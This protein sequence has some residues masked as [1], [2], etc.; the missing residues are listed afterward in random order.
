MTAIMH[1]VTLIVA[2]RGWTTSGDP[3]LFGRPGGELPD[4]FLATL[5]D[6]STHVEVLCPDLEMSMFSMRSAESLAR[7][8]FDAISVRVAAGDV[9]RI[10]LL[11][12][13]T[14]SILA[15][16]VFCMAHGAQRDGTVRQEQAAPWADLIDRNVVLSGITRGWE[17]SSASP[18][19]VRF[20]GPVLYYMSL[21]IGYLKRLFQ[22]GSDGRVAPIPLVYQ[23][24]RGAPFVIASRIQYVAVM[25]ALSRRPRVTESAPLRHEGLPSTVFLLGAQDEFIS[26]A[27]CT[28]LGPRSEF[29]FIELPGTSHSEAIK[30]SDQSPMSLARRERLLAAIAEPLSEL[31]E[32]PWVIPA[33]DIDDYLDPMD[34]ADQRETEA[35]IPEAVEHVVM[36]VHGIRDDGFWTKRVAREIKSLARLQ[37]QS[38]RAPTPTYGYFSMWDFIRPGGRE[39]ATYWFMERYADIRAHFPEARVSFVGHSNG[40]YIAARA[41]KLCAA[42]QFENVVFAG[43]VVRRDYDWTHLRGR[44]ERVLNYV[45]SADGVVAFLP[46]V[47]EAV[48]FSWLDVGGAGAFGFR[49]TEVA[50]NSEPH[51]V[52]EIQFVTGGH[53]AAIVE[54]FWPEIARFALNGEIPSRATASRRRHIAWLYRFAPLVTLT[55]VAIAATILLLPIELALLLARGQLFETWSLAGLV[56]IMTAGLLLSWLTARFLKQW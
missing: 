42:I 25:R 54:S 38:V 28:E 3:L 22:D 32:R 29:I 50:A 47:F 31:R 14:G 39:R 49:R 10:I 7:E 41:L 33:G 55:G 24:A 20:L 15:R 21:I 53:A 35:S 23:V 18:A 43:S 5:N 6:S 4:S 9:G 8:V 56:S 2:V 51:K 27:D 46:A 17:F 45:G 16:R 1:K 26:P 30:V 11:G 44:V 13:S 19:H 40:T 37:K 48:G 36:V 12:Y 34:L 52:H